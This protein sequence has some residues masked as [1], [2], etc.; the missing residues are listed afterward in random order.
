[1]AAGFFAAPRF[2][3]A[4]IKQLAVKEYPMRS[5][6]RAGFVSKSGLAA[7]AL[8]AI[9]GAVLAQTGSEQAAAPGGTSSSS[10]VRALGEMVREL[11]LQVQNLNSRVKVLETSE[12]AASSEAQDLRI[13]L[14]KATRELAFLKQGKDAPS[15]GSAALAGPDP[16]D[17]PGS[18]EPAG[19][20]TEDRVTHLEEDLALANAKITEQSQTKVESSSKYRVRLNGLVLLNLFANRGMVD[21]EDVPQIAG[22]KGLLDSGGTFGGSLRQSQIGLEGFGPE[23][24]GARTHAEVRL[25]FAGGFPPSPNGG[26]SGVMRL[27]TGTVHF[28]WAN[29]SLVAGQDY[30]FFSPLT[31]TSFASLVI[32]ALSYSGNLWAWVP[33]I[34]VEHRIHVSDSSMILLQGGLLESLS[35]DTPDGR[36][37]RGPTWGE[38]S[39]QPAYAGRVALSRRAF[40]QNIVAGLGGY[41]G[42]Q[43]WGFGRSVDAWAGT[44]DVTVPLGRFVEFTGQFYRGRALGGLGGAI[45]QNVLWNGRLSDPATEVYGL[46]SIGGWVQLK[47]KPTAKFEVNGAVGDDN[48]FSSRLRDF[49]ANPIYSGALLS[50]NLGSFVNFIY[51]PRS[52]VVFSLEYKRLKTFTLDSQANAANHINLSVGYIF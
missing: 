38:D 28:D 34:R 31:P 12:K 14:S 16:T 8:L 2:K 15:H 5:D 17:R 9:S 26:L 32:P 30:L 3:R 1:M 10:D 33:Q 51:R 43:G 52:D 37:E 42:R 24:A 4:R 19:Q 46:D 48:P 49:A 27:R 47:L 11:Q 50:K 13:E 41:Y 35:G 40:G 23:I 22:P 44:A 6:L 45:G 29:T 39:G 18:T 25:D 7:L 20:A 21:S 36:Y